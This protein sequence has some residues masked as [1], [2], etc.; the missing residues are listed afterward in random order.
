MLI[1]LSTL[2]KYFGYNSFR[3]GQEEII[4]AIITNN[5]VLTILPTGAGKS[6]CYQVPA[7]ISDNYSIVIS[8]LIALMKD[9]VDSLNQIEEV[10]AF[11]NSTMDYYEAETVL[12]KIAFGKIKL[13]YL[14]P[15][16]LESIKFAERLIEL[17]PSHLFIDEA[18][19]ISEWGHN[20]RPSYMKIREFIEY[21]KIKKVAAFTATA[22][23]EVV[24]DIITQLK[25]KDP[26]V[27][28]RGFEREN[29]HLN[30]ILT[31]NKKHK[32][33]ELI[34]QHPGS[35][36]IYTASR[37]NTEEVAEFLN[38]YG[39]KCT[40]YH[41][42]LT[43]IERR[44]IQDDFINGNTDYIAAT[45]AFGMGIDKKDI[46]LIIHYNVTGSIENYYQEIGRA[47]RDSNESFAYLLYDQKDL[48][49][50]NFFLSNAHPDKD[51]IQKIYKA[52]CDFNR[53]AVNDLPVN[54]LI[55]DSDYISKYAGNQVSKGLLFASL[56]YLE[57]SG[58][59]RLV[60]EFEKKD[61][62]KFL[63]NKERLKD[64]VSTQTNEE[65]KN[66]LL[67]L[68]REFGSQPFLNEIK[69]SVFQLASKLNIPQMEFIDS[70]RMLDNLGFIAFQESV[71]KDTLV[72]TAPRVS[73]DKLKLN[74]KKI[75]ESFIN[76]QRKLDQ[77]V[78]F[79]FSKQCRFRYILSYFGEDVHDYKCRKCDNCT[80]GSKISSSASEYISEIILKSLAEAGQEISESTVLQIIRGERIK[81]S[82][83]QFE[84]FGAC[85]NYSKEELRIVI[86][87]LIAKGL[88]MHSS[89]KIKYLDLT[90]A[91]L[92]KLNELGWT[93]QM[94]VSEEN[95]E[96]DLVLFNQLREVRK[97]AA[98]KFLQ[99][100][101]LICPD[102]VIRR[103]IKEKPKSKSELLNVKGFNQRMFNKLG[104]DFLEVLNNY[105]PEKLKTGDK[106]RSRTIPQNINETYNLLLKKY[107]LREISE[108]RKLSEAVISM[109]IETILEYK[110][111]T[112]I[113]FLFQKGE[114]EK[115]AGVIKNGAESLKEYKNK[116]PSNISYALIRIA[117]AKIRLTSSA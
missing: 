1:L 50:Q 110:S 111:D 79:V 42:G 86:H 93:K 96:T 92:N 36:I 30:V 56:R 75:N 49:I 57:N 14:S 51:T 41:A 117:A 90:K 64:F 9:Q 43:A 3:E 105:S 94:E 77:M 68:L 73:E 88:I 4:E 25:F 109:Q 72:L 98:D 27:F 8:P 70:L 82:I 35:A 112:D 107:S 101:Y 61:S 28:V 26:K 34:K 74:F 58:Y 12:N 17:K 20:F 47:G 95:Y 13:L 76:S 114:F 67:L 6:I 60:S 48:A 100:G 15:E 38:M 7:L 16:K 22:T 2:K 52:V 83:E 33:L 78:E 54:E 65:L 63:V 71:S 103:I 62:F 116:L 85:E 81:K 55:I 69:F 32:C 104:D 21:S 31:K 24:E 10:S 53:V 44:K 113:S 97:K 45:N 108:L 5:H 115:I 59:I 46:R 80:Q 40:Y 106:F 89:G 29:L 84:Y 91:G 23:P 102:E 99:T 18:H 11:I 37:K 66:S 39:I 19:C 87:E